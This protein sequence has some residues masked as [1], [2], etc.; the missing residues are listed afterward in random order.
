MQY[1]LEYSATN[2][3]AQHVFGAYM[4]FLIHPYSAF[5]VQASF[6]FFQTS[7]DG[8]WWTSNSRKQEVTEIFFKTEMRFETLD[9]LYSTDVFV[10]EVNPFEREWLPVTK[11]K[12]V[13]HSESWIVDNYKYIFSSTHRLKSFLSD[14]DLLV[15]ML[16]NKGN[17][18]EKIIALRDQLH[19]Y[20][21]FAPGVTTKQ[22]IASEV[23]QMKKGVCQDFVHVFLAI[24]RNHGIAA[25]YT[26]GY[27]HEGDKMRGASQL[28]AWVECHIPN[29]GWVG[30]DPSNKL[31]VDHNYVKICH[32]YDY[33]DC[34][35]LRGVVNTYSLNQSSNYQV[36]VQQIQ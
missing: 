9:V 27:L 29:V 11:E 4:K 6:P 18:I 1:K 19:A 12:A 13:L 26:S 8:T 20:L 32:G 34:M 24:L 31:L 14:Q 3:Y 33:D 28:H 23:M 36:K 5:G 17:L 16:P 21:E 22:T 7:A 10:P 35:P 25:R 30:I 2:N 15:F